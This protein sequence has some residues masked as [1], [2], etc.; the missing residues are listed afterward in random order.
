MGTCDLARSLRIFDNLEKI[1]T[2]NL[3]EAL[4][5]PKPLALR[6]IQALDKVKA[7]EYP[8]AFG[9]QKSGKIAYFLYEVGINL[10]VNKI[11]AI[12]NVQPQEVTRIEDVWRE[13]N[14]ITFKRCR[15]VGYPKVSERYIAALQQS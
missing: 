12:F 4:H 7:N 2:N 11:A 13:K 8:K 6:V 15:N 10:Q 14:V 5:I 9:Y 1:S 3:V